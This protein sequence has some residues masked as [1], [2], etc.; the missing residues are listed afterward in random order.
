[1]LQ[2]LAVGVDRLY[3]QVCGVL[4]GPSAGELVGMCASAYPVVVS[5]SI[6]LSD[7]YACACDALSLSV[8][9]YS[10]SLHLLQ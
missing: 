7:D 3:R 8:Q 1:M 10:T 9:R 4:G 2:D 5:M 6:H